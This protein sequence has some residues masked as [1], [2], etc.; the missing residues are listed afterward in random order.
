MN[1]TAFIPTPQ[2]L[3]RN[4]LPCLIKRKTSFAGRTNQLSLF[5]QENTIPIKTTFTLT[6]GIIF[7]QNII[8][9]TLITIQLVFI[10]QTILYCLWY[11]DTDLVIIRTIWIVI[12]FTKQT[13]I[14]LPDQTFRAFYCLADIIIFGV[15]D[16]LIPI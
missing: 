15:L 13:L 16:Y 3:V 8:T 9:L 4:A 6:F 14:K 10:V 1:K 2:T 11:T 12:C 7:I 5:F